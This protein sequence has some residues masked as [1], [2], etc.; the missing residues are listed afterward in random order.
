MLLSSIPGER[1]WSEATAAVAAAAVSTVGSAENGVK[2]VYEP[3]VFHSSPAYRSLAYWY[4]R[5]RMVIIKNWLFFS[6]R[7][8]LCLGCFVTTG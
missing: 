8:L 4:C 6:I 5:A 3:T 2:Y 7:E 1:Q